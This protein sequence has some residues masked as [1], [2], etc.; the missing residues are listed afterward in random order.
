[1][2]SY[3]I[4]LFIWL[5]S[6]LI[7]PFLFLY[8]W[9]ARKRERY[10]LSHVAFFLLGLYL[11]AR[12]IEPS[13]LIVNQ[14]NLDLRAVAREGRRHIRIALFADTH[15][16]LY[17]GWDSLRRVVDRVNEERPDIVLIPG[18]FI[19]GSKFDDIRKN[20]SPLKNLDSPAYAVLGNHDFGKSEYVSD[21]VKSAL[22]DCGITVM[23][24]RVLRVQANGH[25]IVLAGLSDYLV[26]GPDYRILDNIMEE[27]FSIVLAHN[28]DAVHSFPNNTADLI[29]SGHTHAGQVRIPFIYKHVIP[30]DYGFD[31]GEYD[32]NGMKV[33]ITAGLGQVGLPLRFL[34]PPVVDIIEAEF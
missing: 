17:R 8:G 11:Y 7:P 5:F 9:R 2:T 34:N 15:I 23:D 1:M 3:Y 22:K 10:L 13:L 28:P 19:F 26:G 6:L 25:E 4:I 20:L 30:T 24:N 12:F 33:F 27:D 16:G 18:D 21:E 31:Q 14:N 32:V 29:V